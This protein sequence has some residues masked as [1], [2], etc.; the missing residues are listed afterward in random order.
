MKLSIVT[1]LYGSAA[2]INEFYERSLL[3]AREL[4]GED[5]EIIFVNDGSPDN[6]LEIGLS[7]MEQDEKIKIID[8]SRNFGHHKAM[9]LGLEHAQGK[10]IFLIDIDLEEQPEWL[11]SFNSLMLFEDADVVYGVQASRKG[12]FFE[13][14]SGY[15]FYRLFRFFTELDQAN[16]LTTARLM[17]S[18]YVQALISHR[19]REINIGGLWVITGFKQCHHEVTKLSTSP[20]VYTNR[21]KLDHLMNSITSFS[22]LPLRFSFYAGV[23]I[24]FSA[25][26]FIGY[27]FY[28]YIFK[29]PPEGYVSV[30]ASIWLF[31]G[32][33]I[34]LN[35]IQGIYISKIFM[36]VKQRPQTIIR[37]IYQTNEQ[38]SL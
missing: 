16:N 22:S 15:F 27:Q 36:E 5:F 29:T 7:L 24:S 10:K 14:M 33:I 17:S 21:H 3:V 23:A 28:L 1:T 35:S 12:N 34:L 6:S 13:R 18:R 31:S 30:I 37:K 26:L 2:Y 9:M 38:D 11:V 4:A 19:E 32:L 25:F 20:S 8:L